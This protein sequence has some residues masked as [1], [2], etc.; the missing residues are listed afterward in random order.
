MLKEACVETVDQ[1]VK[2]QRLGADRIELCSRLDLD[3][4]TPSVSLYK[5]V[6]AVVDLPIHVMIRA[7]PSYPSFPFVLN[8]A[9]IKQAIFE[10]EQYKDLGVQGIVFGALTEHHEVDLRWV[11]IVSK[12]IEGLHFTFHKAVDL[13]TD[14]L[15]AAQKLEEYTSVTHI[16][17]SGGATSASKGVDVLKKMTA[18][19]KEVVVIAA[20]GVTSEN[21]SSLH[22]QINA[23]EYHGRRIVGDLNKG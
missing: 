6:R 12:Y 1:A 16:L 10:I 2:A 18:K 4:L 11:E 5:E 22:A 8:R 19:L 21:I 3:G 20:G 17:T 14:P 9:D 15:R 7:L 23:K 13:C